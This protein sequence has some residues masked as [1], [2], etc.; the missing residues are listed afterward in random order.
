M[1]IRSRKRKPDCVTHDDFIIASAVGDHARCVLP[2]SQQ[3]KAAERKVPELDDF[4]SKRDYQGAITL[5]EFERSGES[6]DNERVLWLAYAYFHYGE[7][8]KVR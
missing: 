1:A 5:L 3:N 4:L 8:D 6:G 2:T 7:H